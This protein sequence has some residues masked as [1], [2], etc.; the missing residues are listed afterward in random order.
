M[1]TPYFKYL[2]YLYVWIFFYFLISHEYIKIQSIHKNGP[3]FNK[4]FYQK[5]KVC[6]KNMITESQTELKNF[7]FL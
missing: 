6:C 2:I 3:D 5:S 1:N 4:N 7:R